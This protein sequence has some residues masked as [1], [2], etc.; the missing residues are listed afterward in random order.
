MQH[1]LKIKFETTNLKESP[2]KR[3]SGLTKKKGIS[4][5]IFKLKKEVTFVKQPYGLKSG[6]KSTQKAKKAVGSSKA[7]AGGKTDKHNGEVKERNINFTEKLQ[8]AF[9]KDVYEESSPS[10]DEEQGEESKKG[11]DHFFKHKKDRKHKEGN[12]IT[13]NLDLGK[14]GLYIL[15]G[16]S[17]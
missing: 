6:G 11:F 8:S 5:P 2:Q 10:T 13:M 14:R 3:L 12:L 16:L 1:D 7:S 9:R 4:K 15:Q 17:S